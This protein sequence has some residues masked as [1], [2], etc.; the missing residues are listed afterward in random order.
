MESAVGVFRAMMEDHLP[1][2]IIIE[3]DLVNYET[4]K[5]YKVLIL[6]NSACLSDEMNANVRRFVKEG[7]GLVAM[8]E[9]SIA[10]EFGD[11]RTDFGLADIMGV[12]FKGTSDHEARWPN[13]PKWV[14]VALDL[15]NPI[16]PIIDDPAIRSAS[17]GGDRT[18]YIGWMTNVALETGTV[19]VGRRLSPKVEWPFIAIN[20]ANP[21]RSVYFA[22]DMGQAYFLAPYHYQ[23][24][25]ISKAVRWAAKDVPPPIKVEA[26][27]CVQTAYYTQNEGKRE[28]V[29]LLNQVNTTANSAIPENGV[30]MRMEVLPIHD[31]KVTALGRTPSKAFL[32]PGETPLPITQTEAGAE[33]TVPKIDIHAMVV[34]E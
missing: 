3:P 29:H 2:D 19:Q 16:H 24:K 5:Q 33:V 30:S 31:I 25:L 15:N 1:L 6:P 12:H 11:Q 21:G 26:P 18:E 28:I 10:D 9:A 14:Q 32:V 20:E 34:F 22:C 17:R 7:G 13:Y 4:L 23:G 27:M 8:H